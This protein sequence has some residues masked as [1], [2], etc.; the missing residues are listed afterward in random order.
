M[1]IRQ[2]ASAASTGLFIFLLCMFIAITGFVLILSSPPKMK[3][4]ISQSGFYDSLVSG[5]LA[6]SQQQTVGLTNPIDT[7]PL[8]RPTIQTAIQTAFPPKLLQTQSETLID[9]LYVWLQGQA[10]QPDFKIDLT[11]AKASFALAMG[12]YTQARLSTLPACTIATPIDTFDAFSSSCLPAG[13]DI[14][15]EVQKVELEV[16][17]S[18]QFLPTTTLTASSFT[19]SSG[20]PLFQQLHELPGYYQTALRLPMVFAVLTIITGIVAVASNLH[21]RR[22]LHRLGT[23]CIGVGLFFIITALLL[24]SLFQNFTNSLNAQPTGSFFTQKFNQIFNQADKFINREY[25]IL[26]A[27]S[28]ALGIVIYIAVNLLPLRF[29]VGAPTADN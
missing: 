17:T 11:S 25:L 18:T 23:I 24:N 29:G 3:S 9:G 26:G 4:A 5:I 14:P 6:Q 13:L 21:K 8:D 28:M 2:V 19:G 1:S 12:N 20:Q 16:A 7:I 10:S 15:S 22:A 27:A